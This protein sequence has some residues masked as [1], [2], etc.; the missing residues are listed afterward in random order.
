MRINWIEL[1]DAFD[2]ASDG[3]YACLDLQTGEVLTW[4]DEAVDEEPLAVIE[5]VQAEPDRYAEI[6]ALDSRTGWQ[7]M[8]AFAETTEEPLR[9]LLSVALDGAGAFR[10]FKNVLADF[11]EA[12]TRWFAFHDE[13]LGAHIDAWIASFGVVVD[14][15]PP[16]TSH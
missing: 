10:R 6:E 16:W 3:R 11:P 12:R 13:R 2:F 8:A 14:N 4:M 9:G 7:W 1:K 5:R 15:P